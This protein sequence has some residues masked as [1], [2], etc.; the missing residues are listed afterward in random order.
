MVVYIETTIKR[1]LGEIPTDPEWF[2]CECVDAKLIG[3]FTETIKTYN[4]FT[5]VYPCDAD[6]EISRRREGLTNLYRNKTVWFDVKTVPREDYELEMAR[7][8]KFE[9]RMKL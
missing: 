3:R 4:E 2:A 8:L 5:C 6:R 7:L 1:T 9:T